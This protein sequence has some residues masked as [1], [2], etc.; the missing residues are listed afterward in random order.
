MTEPARHII[1][2]WNSTLLDDIHAL[3]GCTNLLLEGEGHPPVSLDF[4]QSHYDVPFRQLYNNLGLT[5]DKVQRL[6]ELENSAFHLHYEPMA[7][8]AALRDGAQD[9]L[10]NAQ[11]HGLQTYILSNHIVEPIREQLRRLQIEHFFA[12]V[13]AYANRQVQFKDMTKGERLRRYRAEHGWHDHDAI[14]VGDSVEEIEIAHEQ[15]MIS[16]AITGG[17]VSEQRLA[18]G[19]PDYLIHSLRDLNTI[20]RQEGFVS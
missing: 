20:L 16:V 19:K 3:H 14:I 15:G 7:A 2:D 5:P 17:C 6:I 13:L 12:E 11:T 4:F 18:A 10:Q 1:F 9:I 8:K